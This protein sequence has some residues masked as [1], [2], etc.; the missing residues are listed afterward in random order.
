MNKL[1]G[2][3][4]ERGIRGYSTMKKQEHEAKVQKI[5]QE[6][7]R[8][9]YEEDLRHNAV[10]SACLEQQRIQRQIDEKTHNER[11]FELTIRDLVCE[12]CKHANLAQ[13]GD[14]TFCVL[15]G[16]LQSPGVNASYR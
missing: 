15:C 3:L 7:K 10:C 14:D 11:L 4:K 6:D 13:D 2:F 12:Y 16:A 8:A 1:R 9:E 5:Q